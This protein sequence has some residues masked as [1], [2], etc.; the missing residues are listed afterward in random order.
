[1]QSLSSLAVVERCRLG[2]AFRDE[3]FLDGV[4][5]SIRLEEAAASSRYRRMCRWLCTRK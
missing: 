1:M 2:V 5:G 3:A 4:G